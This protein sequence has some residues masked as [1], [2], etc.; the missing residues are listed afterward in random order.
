ML[1]AVEPG[2]VLAGPGSCT[3]GPIDCQ[4]LSMAPG[5]TERISVRT[6]SGVTSVALFAVTQIS[7]ADHSSAAAADKARRA[8]SAAGRRLLN[9]NSTLTALSLFQY[10][11]SIGAIVDLRNLTVG[12]N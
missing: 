4:I 1:F 9:N 5:Q 7:A 8:E 11:P 6:P 12:G 10:K 2:T 3:P